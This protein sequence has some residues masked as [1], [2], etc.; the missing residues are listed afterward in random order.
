[1]TYKK[2]LKTRRIKKRSKLGGEALTSGGFGCIFKPAL[3]CK[4]TKKRTDGV[5]KMSIEKYGKEEITEIQ[6]IKDRLK[7]IKNYDKYYFIRYR[8]VSTR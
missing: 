4:N 3:K 2:K 8:I 7:S 5:S 6:N 1:M